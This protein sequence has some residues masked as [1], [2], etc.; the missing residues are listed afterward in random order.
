MR[1]GYGAACGRSG[2]ATDKGAPEALASAFFKTPRFDPER[3]V[4]AIFSDICENAPNAVALR[5]GKRTLSYDELD[6]AAR[7][8]AQELILAGVEP[9]SFVA[10]LGARSADAVIA[11]LGILAAGGAYVPLDPTHAP[12][13]LAYI[14][15]DLPLRAALILPG[16]ENDAQKFLPADLPQLAFGTAS[17]K[18]NRTETPLP[19][20]NGGDPAYVMYT[21][22]TT[23]AAKGVIVAQRAIAAQVLDQ[24][25]IAARP[26]DVVL[27]ASTIAC[28]GATFDIWTALLN[29]AT[30]A[31]VTASFPALDAVAGVMVGENVS[32]ALLYTGLFHLMVDHRIDAFKTLR[33]SCAGGDVMSPGHALRLLSAWPKLRL[34]NLYGP[35]ETTVAGLGIEVGPDI[36]PDEPVAIGRPMAHYEAFVVNDDLRPL[37]RGQTGQLALAGPGV[38]LGY[39]G[40]QALTDK[41]FIP[42]PRQRKSGLVYLTGDLARQQRDGTFGFHGRIDRQVKLAGRRIELDG[43][44]HCLRRQKGVG[45]AVVVLVEGAGEKRIAAALRPSGTMPKDQTA[46]VRRVINAAAKSLPKATLP[47][48]TRVLETL[49]LTSA[50]KVDRAALTALLEQPPAGPPSPPAS[51]PDLR[52]RIAAIWDEVLG[53]GQVS[54]DTTFFAAG[55][56]S[57][58]LIDAHAKLEAALGQ[59]F[60]ATLM[61]ETPRLGDLAAKLANLGQQ[62][63]ADTQDSAAA[64]TD[65]SDSAI[66]IIGLAGRFPGAKNL[67]EFWHHIR[68]GDNLIPH[69]ANAEMEDRLAPEI[70]LDPAYVAARPVLDDVEM[71]DAKFFDMLPSEA[72]KM[73]PQGRVLLET[74]VQALEDAGLDPDRS[75]GAIGVFAGATLSTYLLANLMPDRAAIDAFTAA[76]Q[77]G[78]YATLTGNTSDNLAGRIAY[79]LNLK[80]PAISISTAC[81][82]SLTAIAQACQSLRMR[83]SDAALAG[84]VSITFPQKRGYLAQAGG[85]GS[86][87]GICRPFDAAAN[88]TVFGHGAGIVV[89]KRLRDALAAGDQIYATILGAGV[90][91]D[92]ADKISYTAPSVAGQADAIRR[93][94]KDAAIAP[95]TISYVECHGTATPL[96]DPIE[97]SGLLQGFGSSL[98]KHC[99]LGSLKGNIGHLDAAAGV[100]GV[101]KTALMLRHREIPPIANFHAP[102]PKIDLSGSPFFVPT[103]L[104]RWQVKGPR[105]AGVSAFGVGGTNVHLVLEEAPK[106][107]PAARANA[108][109]VQ[110]LPLSAKSPAA[111]GAMKERLAVA[112]SAPNAATLADAAFTLQT[113]RKTHPYRLAIA[114]ATHE[115]AAKALRAIPVPTTKVTDK[116]S[117]VFMFPGQGS[118][119]PGMGRELYATTPDYARWIDRG[120]EIL[121][122]LIGIDIREILHRGKG[123]GA[124][125]A[126]R[127]TGIAQ[128]ALYLSQYALARLFGARGVTPDAL[129]GHSI[130]EFT[131]ATLAGVFDFETGLSLVATRGRLMQG[132]ATGAM[133]SV[134]ATLAELSPLLDNDVDIAARNAAKLQ[135]VSGPKAAI[136]RLTTRLQAAGLAYS[137]L[138]VSH[139]FHSRMMDPVIA[140]L[141]A[142][143]ATV[144]LH[145][146]NIPI[147]SSV[148]GTWMTKDDAQRPTFWAGQVRATVNFQAALQTACKTESPI[149]LE[150]GAGRTLS[151]LAGQILGRGSLGKVFQSLPDHTPS[152]NDENALATAFANLW[153]AGIPVALPSGSHQRGARRVSLPTYPFQRKRHWLEPPKTATTGPVV[154]HS[155]TSGQSPIIDDAMTQP[156]TPPNTSRSERLNGELRTLFSDL[157]GEALG[158]KDADV[159]FLE[160]GFDSLFL[161]QVSQALQAAYGVTISFRS[162]LSTHPTITA[163]ATHLAEI[164]PQELPAAPAAAPAREAAPTGA[165]T[166]PTDALGALIERQMQVMQAVFAEQL[167]AV[168]ACLTAPARSE[169]P[170]LAPSGATT[171]IPLTDSQREIWLAHQLGDLAASSFNESVS[172]HLDGDLDIPALQT[173]LDSVVARHD[174]LRMVFDRS[175][176]TFAIVP[177]LPFDLAQKDVSNQPDPNAALAAI[178]A[179]DAKQP[180]KITQGPPLRAMLVKLAPTRHVL[181][182]TVHH[183]ACDGWSYGVVFTELA[184]LY[185]ARISGKADALLPA[186][187]FAA[188]A[189]ERAKTPTGATVLDFWRAQFQTFPP[190]P[191]LPLDAPRP[192]RRSFAGAT[193]TGFVDADT[194]KAVRTIGGKHGCTL[195]STLLASLQITLG[196]LSNSHDMVIG[197]PMAGQSLL[198]DQALVGHCVN[199][200][201]IRA[202]FEPLEPVASH[203]DRVGKAVLAAMKHQ[204]TTIGA[205]LHKL[206]VSH[207]LARLPL[208]EVL[209]NLERAHDQIDMGDLQ[210]SIS[211]NPKAAT[212]HDLFFSV[213]Q[214]RA[215]LRIDVDYNAEIFTPATITRWIGHFET[216]L[217]EIVRNAARPVAEIPL[218]TVD[219]SHEIGPCE[220]QDCKDLLHDLVARQ[221]AKTPDAVALED[222]HTSLSYAKIAQRSD[223]LAALI[224]TRMPDAGE[225]IAVALPRDVMLP[226]ALLAVLKAGHAYVPLDPRQPPARLRAILKTANVGGLITADPAPDYAHDLPIAVIDPAKAEPG[227]VPTP[228][229]RGPESPAYV[230]FTSGSTGTPKGVEIPHRAVVNFLASMARKPGF[231]AH[232]SILSVTTVMFDIAALELFLPLCVGGRAVLASSDDVLDGFSIVKRLE[233]GDIT[234]MQ[235]TPTLWE[236]LLEAGLEPAKGLKILAGGEAMPGDLATRLTRGGAELWNMYGPTETTIWS[237]LKRLEGGQDITIGGPIDNTE[238]HVLGTADEP[239][240]VGAIGELNIAGAGLALGYFAQPDLSAAAFRDVVLNGRTRTLYRT[241]DLARQRSDGEIEVLGRKDA[242]VKLRGFRIELGDIE[243][244]LRAQPGVAKAAVDLRRRKTGDKQ[245]V[246]YLVANKDAPP[247]TALLAAALA[248][249]LPD[250]MVPQSWI[251]LAALPQTA[252]GKLDRK[253]LPDPDVSAEI[254][255][256]HTQ[257]APQTATEKRLSEIW[258]AALGVEEISTT[259]TL[260]ALGVD[261]LMIFRIAARLLDAGLDIEARDLVA[262]PSIRALAQFADARRVPATA[263]GTTAGGLVRPS[264]KSFRGGAR[265]SPARG[266]LT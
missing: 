104:R 207:T 262:H 34:L 226:V 210:V 32:I 221:A 113:G 54:A 154:L 99:A 259:E 141:A 16:F 53:C 64:P 181:V 62:T 67:K 252:N 184:A 86:A 69:F 56:T 57:V 6:Q 187:S 248:D 213:T 227:Q 18:Q 41:V 255:P 230:I 35:T 20:C 92:G 140:P 123:S 237:A 40:Q 257:T 160:L 234:V 98:P 47:R 176:A 48:L 190:L 149:M 260:Y 106:A 108:K 155:P 109:H 87:D 42:D 228:V 126:M 96:G 136:K 127:D 118:Q 30:L 243:T 240:P 173:A 82:T 11:M 37:R 97:I 172:L 45:E 3:G 264:L 148:T 203:L 174:A 236:M 249:L 179:K 27:H 156:N 182:L 100:M 189:G 70:R 115:K 19:A 85:M 94:H 185:T 202:A 222:G 147:L 256:L 63:A 116:P 95:Q 241:G 245:L 61:F 225:R 266:R 208:T 101:I 186:P 71:F 215:G 28:D 10:V 77:I 88:G 73:D 247:D 191:D 120:A 74:C 122:P 209:F 36:S 214:N 8:I 51:Q 132:V 253:A 130:G 258:C 229:S 114:A 239:L 188:Y 196:R 117:L 131:A 110:I 14:A 25:L 23:G 59:R 137:Q 162:L 150:V 146:P 5:A 178:L 76:F 24:P 124:T 195:F 143:L 112:L 167:D 135:V 199:F 220:G 111:L 66:A 170:A 55:G 119:Y 217:K 153:S 15:D 58:Q 197:V 134:R 29:G 13:Q 158:P 175:G 133:L 211:P 231:T 103:A 4:F 263:A 242:Q 139:A 233:Q 151:T 218:A 7:T 216:V 205:L 121:T 265:R 26:T 43:I 12:E 60:A 204:D 244:K 83:Q 144:S 192:P 68:N 223:A 169:I 31:I 171:A 17:G 198:V 1:A 33:L 142:A 65:I 91:N 177:P 50:G 2:R 80:G 129:I 246:A 193:V 164:L 81:S 138:Q 9:G 145:A 102:N 46:F 128:P 105:R 168:R 107:A 212:A 161:G 21:S 93:A 254:M 52:D 163:L 49:P 39:H 180:I 166:A 152:S 261:S 90:T 159:P 250:Y 201:P 238:L 79:R 38:S 44:E 235:A 89:L 224:Q 165:P 200:L 72:A 78:D 157:S 84:G 194:T 251:M 22:G 219:G 206:D 125:A 75:G 183:I 232:D